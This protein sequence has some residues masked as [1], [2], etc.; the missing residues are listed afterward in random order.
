M[1]LWNSIGG[2][3]RHGLVIG[4]VR[5]CGESPVRARCRPE[6]GPRFTATAAPR[7]R[8]RTNQRDFH[9]PV[10]ITRLSVV[11]SPEMVPV[12]VGYPKTFVGAG[13]GSGGS[14]RGRRAVV[15]ESL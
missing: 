14:D 10:P 11:Q 2:R 4:G 15:I 7:H 5:L 12:W 3:E 13:G 1:E 6:Q 8:I 9:I